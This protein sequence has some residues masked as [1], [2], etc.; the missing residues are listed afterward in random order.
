M[1]MKAALAAVMVVPTLLAGSLA[2]SDPF[3][4]DAV[5]R[6][7]VQTVAFDMDSRLLGVDR[8]TPMTL[9]TGPCGMLLLIR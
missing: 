9:D 4:L 7:E 2:Y 8:G 3:A 1:K 5:A 6:T